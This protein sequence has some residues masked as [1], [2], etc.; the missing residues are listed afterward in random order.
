VRQKRREDDG[1]T[2][3]AIISSCVDSGQ[4]SGPNRRAAGAKQIGAVFS[5]ATTREATK[6]HSKEQIIQ[7]NE[8]NNAKNRKQTAKQR[9]QRKATQKTQRMI[10]AF[11][12]PTKTFLSVPCV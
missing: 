9:K 8:Q 1:E 6:S 2:L 7:T 4:V 11:A 5:Q 12:D 10:K 3:R